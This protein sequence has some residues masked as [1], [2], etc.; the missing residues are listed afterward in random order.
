M[1]RCASCGEYTDSS[2]MIGTVYAVANAPHVLQLFGRHRLFE[3]GEASILVDL[4][5]KS[6]CAVDVECRVRIGSEVDGVTDLFLN[7]PSNPVI[8][9]AAV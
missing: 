1:I 4:V 3:I 6:H 7:A 9:I 5:R 8:Q 2:A